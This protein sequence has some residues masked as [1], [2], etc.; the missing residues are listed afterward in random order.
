MKD[1]CQRLVKA[2]AQIEVD[3]REIGNIPQEGKIPSSSQV[4]PLVLV[5]NTRGYIVKVSNQINGAY[6]NGWFDACSVM[7]R[8]IIE[9]LI[10]EV[11]E[12][13]KLEKKIKNQ[14]G[15]FFFLKDLINE[16]LNETSWTLSRN[17][18]HSLPKLKDVGDKS[19][20]SRR[21]NAIKN[22][23]DVLISDIRN[24]LQELIYLAGLK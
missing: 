19:A 11:F 24:V 4:I 23:I 18:K 3:L 15:D 2:T 8:R 14:N 5:R 12:K 22:D 20:H 16:C 17:T 21:F 6:E 9:T 1:L 10:I 7:I 13:Y